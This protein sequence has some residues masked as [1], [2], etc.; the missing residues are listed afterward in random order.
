M[1]N[2]IYYYGKSKDAPTELQHFLDKKGLSSDYSL[3]HFEEESLNFFPEQLDRKKNYTLIIDED[4]IN[5]H[6]LY[7]VLKIR[8]STLSPYFTIGCIIGKSEDL[9][10]KSYWMKYGIN[11][12]ASNDG[13][14]S[15]FLVQLLYVASD[16]LVPIQRFAETRNIHAKG[17]INLQVYLDSIN[18]FS[19]Q[20]SSDIDVSVTKDLIIK[21]QNSDPLQLKT[22]T[23]AQSPSTGSY[24]QFETTWDLPQESAWAEKSSEFLNWDT[25]K[26]Q[27]DFN[28][29]SKPQRPRKI[30]IISQLSTYITYLK[31]KPAD[32]HGLQITQVEY[33]EDRFEHLLSLEWDAIILGDTP[34]LSPDERYDFSFSVI[35]H[36][37]GTR[38]DCLLFI[39]ESVSKSE[40]VR[41][42]TRYEKIITSQDKLTGASLSTILPA[43]SKPVQTG[44]ESYVLD[45]YSKYTNAFIEH[46]CIITCLSEFFVIFATNVKIPAKS[47]F[48]LDIGFKLP[49]IIV[50]P[51]RE[52][53]RIGDKTQYMAF[54]FG[55]K[56]EQLQTLRQ[57]I[58]YYLQKEVLV[59]D[60]HFL[61]PIIEAS[62]T[63]TL[64][65]VKP[66]LSTPAPEKTELSGTKKIKTY[67][68]KH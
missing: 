42:V 60:S 52:L 8:Q 3:L 62:K 24:S 9:E 17:F 45:R 63:T 53:E 65:P 40:A 57:A 49:L 31:T 20:L 55:L 48:S 15:S 30:L 56:E 38:Q 58:N 22:C 14:L 12:I 43:L 2:P 64:E 16:G 26:T 4:Y 51:I 59:I 50:K 10:K 23:K 5:E 13:D 66:E 6:I 67:Y 47:I 41:K 1:K 7:Q 37:K 46:P 27:L 54:I 29:K 35:D 32:T 11:L 21:L 18:Q 34:S 19:A 25:L 33:T 39:T 61:K 68:T 36:C 28:F 44:V